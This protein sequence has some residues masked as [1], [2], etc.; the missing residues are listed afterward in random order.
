[1]NTKCR[2]C[3]YEWPQYLGDFCS[4]CRRF[5]TPPKERVV[6]QTLVKYSQAP[7]THPVTGIL[8]YPVPLA[9]D[10]WGWL[11]DGFQGPEYFDLGVC[12]MDDH[13]D[14][15]PVDGFP[16]GFDDELPIW[17]ADK[18]GQYYLHIPVCH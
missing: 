10:N 6:I 15:V 13:G 9:Y 12:V 18:A 7:Y 14:A 3:A 5:Q 1:M 8:F 17:A 2:Y 11:K 16:Y 4:E